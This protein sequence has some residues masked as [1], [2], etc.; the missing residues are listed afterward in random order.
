VGE[1]RKVT[2]NEEENNSDQSSKETDGELKSESEVSTEQLLELE[3]TELKEKYGIGDPKNWKSY[4]RALHKEQRERTDEREKNQRMLDDRD[5]RLN[6]MLNTHKLEIEALK[7]KPKEDIL[8]APVYVDNGDPE[9]RIAFLDKRAVYDNKV[10]AKERANTAKEVA[11]LK[12]L[13]MEGQQEAEEQ[14]NLAMVKSVTKG[15]W[16]SKLDMSIEDAEECWN[17]QHTQNGDDRI[18]AIG[19]LYLNSKGNGSKSAIADEIKKRDDIKLDGA[20]PGAGIG[21]GIGENVNT[22]D[23]TKDAD[24][25]SMYETK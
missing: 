21:G 16:M 15:K 10:A 23:F 7:P 17:W 8:E 13:L 25:T 11:E 5:E 19:K 3:D 2:M 9:E 20:A 22:K 12:N 6:E 18:E 24:H 1:L 4:Q 14:K